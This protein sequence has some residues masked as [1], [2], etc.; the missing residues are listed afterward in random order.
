MSTC[1]NEFLDV[2]NSVDFYIKTL[3]YED[4]MD[5]NT[6]KQYIIDSAMLHSILFYAIE[7]F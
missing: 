2:V 7:M 5:I 6:L 1:I 3:Y 4:L